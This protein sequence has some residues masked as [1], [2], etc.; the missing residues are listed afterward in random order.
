MPHYRPTLL[1]RTKHAL[2]IFLLFYSVPLLAFLIIIAILFFLGWRYSAWLE[3]AEQLTPEDQ[4]TV[5]NDALKTIAQ[6]VGGSFFLFTA[7][8]TWRSTRTAEK[9]LAVSQEGQITD[10]LNK[11]I[12][13]VSENDSLAKRLG[14]IY[15]LERIAREYPEE[16]WTIMEILTAYARENP[17]PYEDQ[18]PLQARKRL[19][20][21]TQAILTVLRRRRWQY[22]EWEKHT[23][24]LREIYASGGDLRGAYL[25]GADL[26]RADLRGCDLR[27]AD[28]RKANLMGA[29]LLDADLRGADLREASLTGAEITGVNFGGADLRGADLSAALFFGANFTGADLRGADVRGAYGPF[30]AQFEEATIDQTTKLP[31]KLPTSTQ[32]DLGPAEQGKVSPD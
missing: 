15:A 18:Y 20:T 22:E 27:G 28:L 16:H 23:L 25:R 19:S 32:D 14:G 8:F 30:L 29:H 7:Y 24:N 9:N 2:R 6:V 1:E 26:R 13:N 5:E 3:I 4:I 17:P 12:V 10:R 31:S 11:A 21:D